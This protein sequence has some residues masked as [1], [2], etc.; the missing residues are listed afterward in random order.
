MFLFL[1]VFVS[2]VGILVWLIKGLIEK[3]MEVEAI[4]PTKKQINKIVLKKRKRRNFEKE[5]KVHDDDIDLD[6][7]Y[8]FQEIFPDLH[9]RASE[10]NLN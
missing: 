2:L 4:E 5:N 7:S 3:N 8:D 6:T 10:R 9:K 1:L